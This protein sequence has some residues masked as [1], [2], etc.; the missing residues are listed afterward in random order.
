MSGA[1][2]LHSSVRVTGKPASR[3]RMHRRVLWK[4]PAAELRAPV[5]LE[6]LLQ[7]RSGRAVPDDREVDAAERAQHWHEIGDPFLACE[8]SDVQQERPIGREAVPPAPGRRGVRR[9]E[10]V[11]VNPAR[12]VSQSLEASPPS[13]VE[14]LRSVSIIK[15]HAWSCSCLKF[16]HGFGTPNRSTTCVA[17]FEMT[18]DVTSWA[19]PLSPAGSV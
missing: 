3:A 5:I 9:R 4:R 8:P 12:P 17:S 10:L 13:P 19:V 6:R 18:T 15:S 1:R 11:R 2:L 14:G 7:L 16:G